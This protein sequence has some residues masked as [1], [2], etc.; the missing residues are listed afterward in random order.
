ML[1]SVLTFS[2]RLIAR[3]ATIAVTSFALSS[4]NDLRPSFQSAVMST[5]L[6]DFGCVSPPSETPPC[7]RVEWVDA[8]APALILAL[9]SCNVASFLS[10]SGR[11]PLVQFLHRR[12]RLAVVESRRPLHRLKK[13]HWPCLFSTFF[14]LL[15]LALLI[16]VLLT[17]LWRAR[18]ARRPY[19]LR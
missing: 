7:K 10:R 8:R 11:H 15:A 1:F 9:M 16:C 17:R 6:R 13:Q 5:V 18:G 3:A 12:N 2:E 19:R 14:G 4:E